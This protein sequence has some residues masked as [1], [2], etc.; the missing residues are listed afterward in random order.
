MTLTVRG[1]IGRPNREVAFDTSRFEQWT[2]QGPAVLGIAGGLVDLVSGT[3]VIAASASMEG[4]GTMTGLPASTWPGFFLVGL[5]VLVLA[6]GVYTLSASR[7]MPGSALG[8]LMIGY[9]A[10]MIAVA[11]AMFARLFFVMEGSVLSGTAM[12]LVGGTMIY[13]GWRMTKRRSR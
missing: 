1:R 6:T 3:A 12:I 10:I 7:M 4:T 5:G 2:M 9:G 11:F 13:S 8:G